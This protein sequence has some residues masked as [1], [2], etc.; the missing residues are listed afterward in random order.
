MGSVQIGY[1][2][3][4]YRRYVEGES[5]LFDLNEWTPAPP[6]T[7]SGDSGSTDKP[8]NPTVPDTGDEVQ[9]TGYL[10]AIAVSGAG[11]WALV[12]TKRKRKA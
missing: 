12:Y 7:D 11:L 5:S 3:E 4:A 8:Q 10:L 9:M 6:T 2:L 1:A